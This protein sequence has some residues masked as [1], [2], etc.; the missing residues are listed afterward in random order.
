MS[1]CEKVENAVCCTLHN[2]EC[3]WI[4]LQESGWYRE[5]FRPRPFWDEV[6]LYENIRP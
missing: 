6:F 1:G 4:R 5:R 3:L 2:L